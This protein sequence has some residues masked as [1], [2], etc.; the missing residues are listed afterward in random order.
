MCTA[1][2]SFHFENEV[3]VTIYLL[4]LYTH[5]GDEAEALVRILDLCH[6]VVRVQQRY[7]G[8][9][10]PRGSAVDSEHQSESQRRRVHVERLH[11]LHQRPHRV[12]GRISD[13][14]LYNTPSTVTNPKPKPTPSEILTFVSV[15]AN[16]GYI[17]VR[18]MKQ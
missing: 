15:Q 11:Q 5:I 10:L 12:L 4:A 13:H 8:I 14:H 3:A 1:F 2:S 18:I 7:A 16:P 17:K 6:V 9:L